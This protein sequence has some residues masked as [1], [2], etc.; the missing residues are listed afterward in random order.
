M[1]VPLRANGALNHNRGLSGA[2]LYVCAFFVL[3]GS[4]VI[5]YR[6]ISVMFFQHSYFVQEAKS[7]YNNPSALLA[8]RGGI[9]LSDLSTGNNVLAAAN[10]N[11]YF[12]FG[13]NYKIESPDDAAVK[14]SEIVNIPVEELKTKLNE[15]GK[16][17]QVLAHNIT[18]EQ[19]DKITK[20]KVD[21]ISSASEISRQYQFSPEIS[22]VSGFVGFKGEERI[23]QYGV[24]GYYED[25]LS[26]KL[27]TQEILGN[28]T[29]SKIYNFLKLNGDKTANNTDKNSENSADGSAGYK[30]VDLV[31]AI[32]P[33]IQSYVST[34]LNEL[35]KRWTPEKGMAIVQDPNTGEILAMVASPG[36][37]SNNYNDFKMDNYINPNIQEY[38]EP[39]S[40]FKSITMAAALDTGAVTPETTYR[41]PGQ[42]KFDDFTIQNYD[43]KAHGVQ[44][45]RQVLEFSL[46]TGAIFA[47][48]R[49]GDDNFLNYVVNF[50]FGQKT[51]VDLAGEISGS[52]ANLYSGRKVNFATASFGQGIAVTPIQLITAYSAIANGGK[53]MW[54][55]VVK[56]IVRPDG[57]HDKI[58]PKILNM[59]IKEKTSALMKSMLVDV[60]DKGFD[61]AKVDGYDV[62][63]KTGTAQIPDPEGGYLGNDEFIHDFV[64]FA[65]AYAPRFSILLR[66]DKPV[67]AKFA[68]NTLPSTFGDITRYLLNYFNIPPT[69]S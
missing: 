40:S 23:G 60:V 69:R 33:N 56:E 38:F 14:V 35:M 36:Y 58:N 68:S 16:S 45:M 13:N 20:L 27:K 52:I 65:P 54:P 11:S 4:A 7:Q 12:V 66:I 39:G 30:G 6:L 37:D 21:G 19:A 61:K 29:Y 51:G 41:D 64:G 34:K 9:Y 17:Y 32:D 53:I 28:E 2:R 49:T 63:G 59:A 47:Q 26:G 50:G 31:L 3:F 5:F 25:F 18:K 57:T 44:T 15:A 1:A 10:K 43:E 67:G 46:N 42:V 48:K 62:A 24:E 22:S 8:G 55:H